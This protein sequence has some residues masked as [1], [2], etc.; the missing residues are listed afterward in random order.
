MNK[1]IRGVENQK[2]TIRKMRFFLHLQKLEIFIFY[3]GTS[4]ILDPAA[5]RLRTGVKVG[6]FFS[7][8]HSWVNLVSYCSVL[9]FT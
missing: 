3:V 2:T 1:Y 6:H 5:K 8:R 9:D 7:P 4:K